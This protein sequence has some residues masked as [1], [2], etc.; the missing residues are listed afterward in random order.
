M[1]GERG[2][3]RFIIA[4]PSQTQVPTENWTLNEVKELIKNNQM[5]FQEADLKVVDDIQYKKIRQGKED[6]SPLHKLQNKKS[7][8]KPWQ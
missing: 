3:R 4:N 1:E 7:V 5:K 2:G 8:S 6:K